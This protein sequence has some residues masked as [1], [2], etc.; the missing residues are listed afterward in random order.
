MGKWEM[1][2]YTVEQLNN[3]YK[4]GGDQEIKNLIIL[5]Q[6]TIIMIGM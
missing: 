2:K 6:R 3:D 4:S 1:S 5:F